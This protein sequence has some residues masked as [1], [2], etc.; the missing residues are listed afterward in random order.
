MSEEAN[1]TLVRYRPRRNLASRPLFPE[2]SNLLGQA[3]EQVFDNAAEGIGWSP[4]VDIVE[5]NGG[6]RLTAELPGMKPDDLQLEIMDG[7]L[8]LRGEKRLDVDE[9]KDNVRLVERR[10]GAFERSFT[11]PVSVDPE[12]VRAEYTDGV[13]TVHM[14]KSEAAMGR[15]VEIKTA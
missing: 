5:Q 10:Y 7:T 11:L 6:L 2:V 1:M 14:P 9:T 13:L 8:H 4:S 12:R 15:K 3:I